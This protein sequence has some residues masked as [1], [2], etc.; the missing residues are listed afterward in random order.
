MAYSKNV[1]ACREHSENL[2]AKFMLYKEGI[3]VIP[4]NETH[5]SWHLLDGKGEPT[6]ATAAGFMVLNPAD[7]SLRSA[8]FVGGSEE[9]GLTADAVPVYWWARHS[10]M[11]QTIF[12]VGLIGRQTNAFF[13]PLMGT[14]GSFVRVG[15]EP[16]SH[17]FRAVTF[18][19]LRGTMVRG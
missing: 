4:L 1:C 7:D 15:N 11:Q 12:R 3:G 6:L 16:A 5:D 9:L 2:Y 13:I 19:E 14:H 18:D 17:S 10:E 8:Q